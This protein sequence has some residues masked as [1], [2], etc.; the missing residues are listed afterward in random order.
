MILCDMRHLVAGFIKRSTF[1]EGQI[2]VKIKL[3][4]D[5]NP[6]RGSNNLLLLVFEIHSKPTIL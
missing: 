4:Y 1:V 6:R 3:K 2:I 5:K